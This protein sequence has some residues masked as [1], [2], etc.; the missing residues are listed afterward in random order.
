MAFIGAKPT[1]VPLTSADLEDGIISNSKLS[2]DIISGETELA[3]S[4]A[5]TDELLIS[6]AGTLKRIDYSLISNRPAFEAS[7][8]AH[9]SIADNA[10][11]KVQFDIEI[12]D[13]D[14][15]YDNS[16]NY[17]FTPNVAG[18]YYVALSTTVDDGAG[19]LRQATCRIYKNGSSIAISKINFDRSSV[20]NEGEG[21]TPTCITIVDMNG[22]SDYLEGLVD[23]D[24]NDGGTANIQGH[25]TERTSRFSA[26]KLIGI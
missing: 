26:Y 22:S 1:N 25:G 24:T 10:N 4:P 5:S 6:D 2:Q 21:C 11:D 17:R 13:T 8:S 7:L 9:Q 20:N 3:E 16:T 18:K 19:T 15:C 23:V 12:L 14:N